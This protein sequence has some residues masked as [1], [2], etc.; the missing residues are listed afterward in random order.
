MK[1]NKY[2]IKEILEITESIVTIIMFIMAI[3]GTI[4]TYEQGFW[5]KLNRIVDHY[6]KEITFVTKDI[7]LEEKLKKTEKEL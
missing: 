7:P 6:H 2:N 4:V 1:Q 3:W 5:H